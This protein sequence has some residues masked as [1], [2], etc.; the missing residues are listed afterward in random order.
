[1]KENEYRITFV[2]LSPFRIMRRAVAPNAIIIMDTERN[3]KV[4]PNVN[5][6]RKGVDKV[7]KSKW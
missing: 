1:M 2:H 6:I 4:K 3:N 5:L 7:Y